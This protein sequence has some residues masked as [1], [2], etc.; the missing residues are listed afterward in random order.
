MVLPALIHGS[1]YGDCVAIENRVAY[2]ANSS[3]FTNELSIGDKTSKES[4]IGVSLLEW[5]LGIGSSE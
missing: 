2:G 4:P 5:R 3:G 1:V